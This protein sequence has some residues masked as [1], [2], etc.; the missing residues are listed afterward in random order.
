MIPLKVK[1]TTNSV[2]KSYIPPD[3]M[4]GVLQAIPQYTSYTLEDTG[5][6]ISISSS[7]GRDLN[8][9]WI[10]MLN[11][12]KMP[13]R[14]MTG[15]RNGW[16]QVYNGKTGGIQVFMGYPQGYFDASG[17]GIEYSGWEGWHLCNGQ[18]GT[19]NLRDF[20]LIPGYRW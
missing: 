5:A 14:L 2:P 18:D 17:R 13:P 19:F 10:W 12:Y 3:D 16:W 8:G 11:Q 1:V 4:Q 6:D 9:L 20:F 7:G 15:Y